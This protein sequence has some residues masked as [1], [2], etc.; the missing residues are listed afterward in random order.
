MPLAMSS[1]SALKSA[2]MR[3][4]SESKS[5]KAI[6]P[7]VCAISLIRA[8]ERFA[9]LASPP[10][11][12]RFLSHAF[13]RF[14]RVEGLTVWYFARSLATAVRILSDCVAIAVSSRSITSSSGMSTAYRVRLAGSPFGNCPGVFSSLT[15]VVSALSMIS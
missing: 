2:S 4:K 14:S 9:S 6:G 15:V 5:R 7:S 3:S 12:S 11:S 13:L 1:I 10:K 8:I